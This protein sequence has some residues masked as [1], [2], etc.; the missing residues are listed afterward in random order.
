VKRFSIEIIN[1]VFFLNSTSIFRTRLL[2]ENSMWLEETT[3]RTMHIGHPEV[4]FINLFFIYYSIL[5][6]F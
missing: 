4:N 5:F 1:K 6:S 2:A 3:L